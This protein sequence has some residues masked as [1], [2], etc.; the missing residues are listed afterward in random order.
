MEENKIRNI[1]D[2]IELVD[3]LKKDLIYKEKVQDNSFNFIAASM[4]STNPLTGNTM[5]IAKYKINGYEFRFE[6]EFDQFSTKEEEMNKLYNN[7]GTRIAYEIVNTYLKN[8]ENG[9]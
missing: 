3:R 9:K 2:S 6:E 7:I 4:S 8:K 1:I 5:F